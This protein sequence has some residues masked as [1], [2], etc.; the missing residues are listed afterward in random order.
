MICAAGGRRAEDDG[1]VGLSLGA[2]GGQVSED[3]PA[4]VE[5]FELL[6]QENSGLMTNRQRKS[7]EERG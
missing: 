5:Y 1:A 2:S 4:F 6:R 7:R 3:L